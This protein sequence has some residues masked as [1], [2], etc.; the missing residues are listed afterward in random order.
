MNA[1]F[2]LLSKW[3]FCTRQLNGFKSLTERTAAKNLL[4]RFVDTLCTHQN[5]FLMHF[6]GQNIGR[7]RSGFFTGDAQFDIEVVGDGLVN[8]CDLRSIGRANPST[9]AAQWV[10]VF[11]NAFG[12]AHIHL[13]DLIQFV[14]KKARMFALPSVPSDDGKITIEPAS[15]GGQLAIGK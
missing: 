4:R 14:L 3:C 11:D 12:T 8:L 5:G 10:N 1:A 13:L 9:M 2:A 7:S 15:V 6:F